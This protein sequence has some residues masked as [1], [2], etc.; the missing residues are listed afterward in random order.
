LGGG[1]HSKR[2]AEQHKQDY[3]HTN[4]GRDYAQGG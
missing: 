4:S 2:G 1:G 3:S